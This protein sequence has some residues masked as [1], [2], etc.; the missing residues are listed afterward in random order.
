MQ[1]GPQKEVNLEKEEEEVE[2]IEDV[3]GEDLNGDE[4]DQEGGKEEE[5]MIHE[6]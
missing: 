5:D 4:V 2:G 6:D 1:A 3:E